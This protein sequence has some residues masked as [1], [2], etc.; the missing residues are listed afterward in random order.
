MAIEDSKRSRQQKE[1]RIID[2]LEPVLNAQ[3]LIV[4]P[5]VIEARTS[6]APRSIRPGRQNR[7]RAGFYQMRA[8]VH[9]GARLARQGWTA[10]TP[11]LWEW[12]TARLPVQ[13]TPTKAKSDYEGPPTQ[14]GTQSGGS[15]ARTPWELP[16]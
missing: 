4:S 5:S 14:G 16:W 8:R 2:T 6:A 12:A 15:A 13:G 1:A 10:W 7:L 11:W 9:Q 3:R